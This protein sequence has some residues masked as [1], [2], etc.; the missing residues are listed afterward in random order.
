MGP[1]GGRRIYLFTNTVAGSGYQAAVLAELVGMVFSIEID[2]QRAAAATRVLEELHYRNVRMR[3]G[4]GRNGWPEAA[5]FD[6]ILVTAAAERLPRRLVAQLAPGAPL[7]APVGP[8]GE[9]TLRVYRRL[10]DGRLHEERTSSV[11]VVR[12]RCY[13]YLLSPAF[14]QVWF[15]PLNDH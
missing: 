10:A 8:E 6:A 11:R 14:C 5:P 12:N 2:T 9:Q 7:V 15:E 1:L 13:D 3:T 4:D